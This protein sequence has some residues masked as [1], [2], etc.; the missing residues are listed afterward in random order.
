M[1][2]SEGLWQNYTLRK[3]ETELWLWV[4]TE[5]FKLDLLSII[6][7]LAS[8]RLSRSLTSLLCSHKSLVISHEFSED[9]EAAAINVNI[10][11]L[12]LFLLPLKSLL[13]K[14]CI[15][16]LSL[17]LFPLRLW[18]SGLMS[19]VFSKLFQMMW[20][21]ERHWQI[22]FFIIIIFINIGWLLYL[23]L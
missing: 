4:L 12:L 18:K 3:F 23:R 20:L 13:F 8:R 6:L 21:L 1:L 22:F 17:L 9:W 16:L 10:L 19:M 5:I 2:L 11:V 15:K 14:N 7:C